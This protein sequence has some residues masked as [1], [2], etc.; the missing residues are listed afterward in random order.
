MVFFLIFFYHNTHQDKFIFSWNIVPEINKFIWVALQ[1]VIQPSNK[2]RRSIMVIELKT[3]EEKQVASIAHVGPVEDMGKLIGELTGWVMREELEIIEPPFVVYYT[4]PMEV[5]PDKMEYVVGIPFEGKVNSDGRVKIKIMPEHH[6]LFTLHKGTYQKIGSTYAMMMEHVMKEGHEMIGAPR[7]SYLNSPEEVPENELLTEIQFP[8]V[9]SSVT[10]DYCSSMEFY[11]IPDGKEAYKIYK[12]G[13]VKN[14]NSHAYLEISEQ[15]RPALK[16][17]KDFSH[18]IVF[19][20]ADKVDK[21]KYRGALRTIP[22]YAINKSTGVF[23]TRAEYR[24]N[25]LAMTTCRIMNV[26]EKNG[27]ITIAGIDAFDGTPIIDL[28]PYIPAFDRVKDPKLPKWLS[29]LWSEWKGE[30]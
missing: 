25:P 26:E 14:Q 4:S 20:W 18:V 21:D 5:S 6:A 2:K 27:K 23:S 30:Y 15:Y 13:R 17:L 7:E 22:P 8:V 29:F 11:E 9:K 10:G 19:W 3:I 12:I 24:P 28:K 1:S 16:H